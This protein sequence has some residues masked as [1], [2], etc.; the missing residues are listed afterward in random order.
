MNHP[1]VGIRVVFASA[2]QVG[3]SCCLRISAA[4]FNAGSAVFSDWFETALNS[5]AELMVDG[6]CSCSVSGLSR[7]RV[8]FSLDKSLEIYLV[9][10]PVAF[11]LQPRKYVV[12]WSG[13]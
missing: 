3:L 11:W 12:Y 7:S 5:L 6:A 2:L 9:K 4:P 8:L 1:G 10:R 13:L